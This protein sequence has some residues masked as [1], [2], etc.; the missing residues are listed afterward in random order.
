MLMPRSS[1]VGLFLLGALL[2]GVGGVGVS[3]YVYEIRPQRRE[4]AELE[5]CRKGAA[6]PRASGEDRLGG[7][8][9]H[10]YLIT[11]QDGISDLTKD[12]FFIDG[13]YRNTFSSESSYGHYFVLG[14]TVCVFETEKSSFPTFRIMVKENSDLWYV[15]YGN[16]GKKL[17]SFALM[18]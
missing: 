17:R 3:Y 15:V 12:T 6:I 9:L 5:L 8:D 10:R 7:T 2:G 16:D 11:H 18:L 14:P 13:A 4:F 1:A